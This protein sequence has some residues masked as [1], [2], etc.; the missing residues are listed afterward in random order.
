MLVQYFLLL[1]D[2]LKQ[3]MNEHNELIIN[4]LNLH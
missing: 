4:N 2:T 1:L 3:E